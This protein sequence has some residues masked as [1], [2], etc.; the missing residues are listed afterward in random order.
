MQTTAV[1]GH[2]KA[3]E[4]G[5]NFVSVFKNISR[6]HLHL[7]ISNISVTPFPLS[8]LMFLMS[9]SCENMTEFIEC[10]EVILS[11]VGWYA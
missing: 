5:S 2:T 6:H 8:V 10:S 3:E 11:R 9:S 1:Y 4:V 7:F